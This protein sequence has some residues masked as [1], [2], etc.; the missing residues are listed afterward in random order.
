MA[1]A[2][3]R[4]QRYREREDRVRDQTTTPRTSIVVSL[5]LSRTARW[6]RRPDTP[7]H[8]PNVTVTASLLT[9]YVPHYGVRSP[10]C[11]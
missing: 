9:A 8:G 11:R 4:R 3:S 1:E 6:T 5:S 2:S 7:R 10:G